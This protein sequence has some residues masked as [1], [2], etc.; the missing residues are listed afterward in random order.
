MLEF[1]PMGTEPLFS[2]A[3][4]GN[5][6]VLLQRHGGAPSG[7][8]PAM[9]IAKGEVA[10]RF[11]VSLGGGAVPMLRAELSLQSPLAEALAAEGE[12]MLVTLGDSAPLVLPPNGLIGDYLSSCASARPQVAGTNSAAPAPAPLNVTAPANSASPAPSTNAAT[13]Q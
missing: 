5:R 12:P 3:C 6:S 8:L 13:P 10:E 4:T 7:P 1:G 2:M 11:N 9:Q